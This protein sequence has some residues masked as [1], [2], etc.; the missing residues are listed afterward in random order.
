MRFLVGLFGGVFALVAAISG[1][2]LLSSRFS[3]DDDYGH[4]RRVEALA[5]LSPHTPAGLVRISARGMVFRARVAGLEGDGPALVLLH[6]FPE[7]SIMW[8]PLLGP[9]A[10]A[11][12]RAVAFDQRGYSPG[13]R[14]DSSDAY[15][16]VTLQQDVLAVADALGFAKFHLVGHDWGSLVGWN[17]TTN[18]PDRVLTW[19]SLSIS[20]PGAVQAT[21]QGQGPPLYVRIFRIPGV[22]ETLFRARG[23]GLLRNVLYQEMPPEQ[24]EEYLRVFAEPGAMRAALNWYR[25][26]S[27]G[28]G[29]DAVVSGKIT[30]PV[31]YLYGTKDLPMFVNERV[32]KEMPRFLEGPYQ[33]FEY[34]AGHWLIQAKPGPV[35]ERVMEHLEKYRDLKG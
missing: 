33:S 6:G 28:F 4:T 10:E 21:R 12:F 9:V 27:V 26:L 30:Q 20:H 18:H 7:T 13:A 34:D 31:L 3:L 16:V 19:T 5:P 29:D 17:L 22:M 8:E 1:L 25:A 24:V 2:L 23:L 15:T 32:R 11:G 35:V 14:P